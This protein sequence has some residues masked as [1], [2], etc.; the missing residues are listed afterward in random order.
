MGAVAFVLLIAC[1]N[2]ANLLLGRAAGGRARSRCASS[3]GASR[4]RIVRQLL[5]ESVLLA[6]IG[7]VLGLAL[8][9]LG[10]KWFDSLV[11]TDIG[12]PYWMTFTMD[13]IVFVLPRR[14]LPRDRHPLRPRAGAA[15]L[16]DRSQRGDEGR[17]RRP[18]RHRRPARP[19]LDQRAHRASRSR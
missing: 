6:A 2:V 13:P 11:T 8:A 3:L 14:R 5:V 7:G 4:W 18:R 19:A 17:R 16:E 9:V 10:I 12:K 1:A 15:R